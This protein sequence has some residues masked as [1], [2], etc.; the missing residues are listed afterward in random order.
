MPKKFYT[1]RDIEELFANGINSVDITGEVVLTELAYE[2]AQNLGIKLGSAIQTPP[3]APF[4][5][6]LSKDVKPLESSSGAASPSSQDDNNLR[7][8]VREAVAARL[9]NQVDPE[10]LDTIIHRI[11]SNISL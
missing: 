5:P 7:K 11:L 8:R 9:G 1:E 10:L 6:Y 4:R 3:S 2:K